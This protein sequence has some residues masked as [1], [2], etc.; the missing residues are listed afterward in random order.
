VR[1]A[2][3][4]TTGRW[5]LL[6]LGLIDLFYYD[7]EIFPFVDGRLLLR[8]NNGTGKSKVL[9]LTLP[10]LLDGDLSAR[11]VEPDADP[12]KRMEWNLLL[13]GTH[14][15]A[16][17]LG[18]TWIEFGRLGDDGAPVYRTLGAGLKAGSGRMLRNWFFI[19]R[20]RVGDDLELLDASRTAL[21]RERLAEALG[22]HGRIYD[23]KSAYRHAVDETL[24]G[25][26][27]KRYDA[28]VDLL[29]QIR[30]PQLSRR[31]NE[32]MLSD[33]LTRSLS[34]VPSSLINVV[35][36]G[37]RGLDDEREQLAELADTTRAVAAFLEHYRAY[38]RVIA[39]RKAEG[40]R[41]AQSKFEQL[42]RDLLRVR[43]ELEAARAEV[44]R[45][46][47][48][49]DALRGRAASLE[50]TFTALM[51]GEHAEGEAQLAAAE[52]EATGARERLTAAVAFAARTEAE[53]ADAR[54]RVE[55]AEA[56]SAARGAAR[57]AALADAGA[58]AVPAGV[59][60]EHA[61]LVDAAAATDAERADAKR[62]ADELLARRR[63]A[64]AHV[65]ELIDAA[66]RAAAALATANGRLDDAAAQ[67]DRALE[68][69]AAMEA[70]L[71]RTGE[72]LVRTVRAYLETLVE[73]RLDDL[74]AVTDELHAW[75]ATLDG[76]NPAAAALTAASDAALEAIGDARTRAR[77][78]ADELAT[79]AEEL[80]REIA[81]LE[82]GKSE[83]P[84]ARHT[85]A[86]GDL[87]GLP[88]WRSVDFSEATGARERAGLE[89]ALEAAG[90]LDAHVLPGGEV[91][92]AIDGELLFTPRPAPAG[93]ETL[94]SV[95]RPAT[96]P[97]DAGVRAEDV[98]AVLAA[99][100]L[101]RAGDT[102]VPDAHASWASTDGRF[103]LGIATGAWSKAEASYIG[104]GA[105]EAAR[106]RR[107]AEVR[108][109]RA[110]LQLEWDALT[111]T[112]EELDLRR[113]RVRAD[114][115]GLPADAV[116]RDAHADVAA[117]QRAVG[118]AR[119]AH[120][121]A[122]ERAEV[123]RAAWDAHTADLSETAAALHLPTARDELETVRDAMETYARALQSLWHASDLAATEERRLHAALAERGRAE[124]RH[125]EADSERQRRAEERAAA[126]ARF[127]TLE[128]TLGADVREFQ[129]RR[130][131][132]TRERKETADATDRT[133]EERSRAERAEA[134]REEVERSIL[135]Q[136]GDA[137]VARDEASAALRRTARLGLLAV[138]VPEAPIPG[139]DRPWT[140][141]QAI[142]VA[143]TLDAALV[144]T[145][146]DDAAWGRVQTRLSQEFTQLQTALSRHGHTAVGEPSDDG[147]AVSIVFGGRPM[148]ATE[149]MTSLRADTE[150]RERLLSARERE[151]IENHLVTEVGANLADLVTGAEAQVLAINA[152]LSERPT[153]TGMRLRVRW[154]PRRDGPAGLAEVRGRLLQ[155]SDAWSEGDR[156]SIGAFLQAR[157]AA[158]READ[159]TGTWYEHLEVALDYRAWHHFT[160]ERFQ[161]G[162]WRP[163]T[164]PA[165]GGE[166]VLA[167]SL[168]LFAAAASHY[169]SASKPHAARLV[170]LDE[171]FAGVDDDSRAK[172]LGLLRAFDLDVVMTSER[173]WGCYAE[174]PGLSIAQLSRIEGIPAVLVSLWAWDGH[175]RR[176]VDSA[177]D[178]VP[179]ADG[180]WA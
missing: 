125:A 95:L 162:D 144:T 58:A 172:S 153:S 24:F 165:S 42:G 72:V 135:A 40:P 156:Q 75:V 147:Y 3:T 48:A 19:T 91:R 76:P 60:A 10:F 17:R 126:A 108:S 27:E 33:A 98:A 9:A 13:G 38:A 128:S 100:A 81:G 96:P 131:E 49:L 152:E 148:P 169:R 57:A 116:L 39:R 129:R 161:H 1:D 8:G 122:A 25:L 4:P 46:A 164:G 127:E 102:R 124:T 65:R 93:R 78:R 35:A 53:L 77:A 41:L 47:E 146:A 12:N 11:R 82:S 101:V 63:R 43:E 179:A 174:V 31:P 30:Q 138:A 175:E 16:E 109:E 55:G 106:R 5:Q 87:P 110:T 6:R 45:T 149:L 120:D 15:H 111:T 37:F 166:R 151:I 84:P 21:G 74:A 154:R 178:P 89:A 80:D 64:L 119:G 123:A 68:R 66:E 71:Q 141:T 157:I 118:D 94:A 167:V 171:A 150:A 32:G 158:V 50:A 7:E 173:E 67:L 170:T 176:R 112:I 140:L 139:D 20:Q 70:A 92:S 177:V 160:V 159:E 26:G 51:E 155:V 62:R 85:R 121:D 28:L 14:P 56:D 143:R 103:G 99:V 44:R 137:A 29:V 73:V 105:R 79:H 168:P 88:L 83:P 104:E 23:T 36:E 115:A 133:L 113:S 163:A 117:A 69:Q 132:V 34:P 180:L 145:N 107:L 2:P 134:G 97:D 114:T 59:P 136:Q 18:Y 142:A 52:R 86:Q 54:E 130:A 22:D 90:L 61:T